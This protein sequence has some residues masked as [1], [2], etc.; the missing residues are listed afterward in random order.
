MSEHK[1]TPSQR[2]ELENLETFRDRPAG[3]NDRCALHD[4]GLIMG[5]AGRKWALTDAGVAARETKV[6]E[7]K[8]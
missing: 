1:L 4:M 5:V 8:V 3:F 6:V 7:G 2:F